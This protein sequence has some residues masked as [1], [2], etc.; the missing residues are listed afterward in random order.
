[1]AV[2]LFKSNCISDVKFFLGNLG[3]FSAIVK[4]LVLEG[5]A[6]TSILAVALA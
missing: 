3:Q 4:Q 1:M 2:D 6:T 5:L